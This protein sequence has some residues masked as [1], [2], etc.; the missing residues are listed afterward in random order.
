MLWITYLAAL[1]LFKGYFSLFD[2]Y[3][4]DYCWVSDCLLMLDA[5]YTC[6]MQ[7]IHA[8]CIIYMLYASIQSIELVDSF[9]WANS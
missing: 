1:S 9:E 4:T 2:P 3:K 5:T 7:H 6:L 8:V